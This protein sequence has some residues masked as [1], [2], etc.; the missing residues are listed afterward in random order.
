MELK[1]KFKTSSSD[2]YMI[3]VY[4]VSKAGLRSYCTV[5]IENYHVTAPVTFLS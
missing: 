3:H 4:L 1:F 2:P 5:Q